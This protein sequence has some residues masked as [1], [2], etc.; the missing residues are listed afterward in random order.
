MGFSA[1]WR[2]GVSK[3]LP[4]CRRGFLGL[5]LGLGVDAREIGM[6]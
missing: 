1:T 5:G 6:W 3:V 4:F 2:L